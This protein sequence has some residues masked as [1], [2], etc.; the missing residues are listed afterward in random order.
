M[1]GLARRREHRLHTSVEREI[2][3]G[4]FLS[5]NARLFFLSVS[6]SVSL[7]LSLS[8]PPLLSLPLSR[9]FL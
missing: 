3:E 7:C 4:M 6:L 8:L 2:V 9:S 5:T 1:V